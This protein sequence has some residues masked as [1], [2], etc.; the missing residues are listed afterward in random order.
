MGDGDSLELFPSTGEPED[1]SASPA[2]P[3]HPARPLAERMRPRNLDE[4]LGQDA[5][6]APG[7]PLRTLIERGEL[8]SLL[9]WGP[10]GTGKTTLA[11][12]L[13]GSPD[14]DFV[15][16]SAVVAGIKDVRAVVAD[17][18]RSRRLGRRTVLFLDEIHRFNRA[19][20]DALLPHVEAGTITLVGATTENPSFEVIGPLLSRTRVFTLQALGFSDLVALLE[21]ALV[22]EER[23]LGTSGV[24]ADPEAI[25]AVAEAAD[26]DARRALG[27]L[28]TAVAIHAAS[29][30]EG[31]LTPEAV[32]DAVGRRML[33]HDRDREEH[34][35]VVSAF[36]K[37]L[38]ASDPDAAL[39]YLARMLEGGDDPLFLARRLVVFAS[40]DV[41]N[42][43]PAALPLALAAY[44]TIER[45]GLPEG[46]LTLAQAT[47][48]LATAPKSNASMLAL[49]RATE[50][51]RQHGNAEVPMH[52]RN[53]P[54]G[55][56]KEQGYGEGYQYP[57]DQPDTFVPDRNLP[58]A[59]G[60]V[61]FYRPTRFGREEPIA[62][63]LAAWR[64]KRR[65]AD[66]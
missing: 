56:M 46:R 37:S 17:A 45:I 15:P 20:Q 19:Q 49:D 23:G 2:H 54:T 9:L 27:M 52:L 12:L 58:D 34:Y 60:E 63:R 64:E 6:L 44:Q 47:T 7:A 21:R 53:A 28:E 30:N 26:G 38:R 55:F 1:R 57:H 25:R 14:S 48:F 40:E 50:A 32:R 31:M 8:P 39:Y 3:T 36:I 13:A 41:S 65:R 29:G 11:R 51:V 22:D 33:L 5:L 24:E 18:E 66:R 43:E 42:A 62:D 61:E 10:P 59:L 16:L 4:V 35:N